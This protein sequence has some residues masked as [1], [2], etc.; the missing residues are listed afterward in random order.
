[1]IVIAHFFAVASPG[2]DFAVVLKQ[3]VQQGR[4][5]ALWTSAGVGA[6]ILLHVAYCVL[7]VALILTQSPS[8]FM[9][10]KYLAGAYLAY[11]GVQALRAAKP[12]ASNEGEAAK[13][14]ENKTVQE[15]SVWLAF[16]RGFFT[17]ALNPKATLFFMSLFT[18]VISPTT[19]TSVQIGYGVY[20]AL[21]TWA[22]FSM[23]SII[24]SR[25]N[26]RGFFQQRGYWFDRGIGVILIALAVRVVI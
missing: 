8:L 1:M 7:G 12:T 14:V 24:L 20:M 5:N 9:A 23:L 3:S 10:L 16:R 25:N 18:L 15:E 13:D 22:W 11:L 4:R 2:P 6:A 17:N 21:A 19:P 26:V